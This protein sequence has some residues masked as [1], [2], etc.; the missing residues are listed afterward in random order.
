VAESKA[1]LSAVLRHSDRPLQLLAVR[2]PDGPFPENSWQ[3]SGLGYAGCES[4]ACENVPIHGCPIAQPAV[5]MSDLASQSIREWVPIGKQ[6]FAGAD[7]CQF[8]KRGQMMFNHISIGVRSLPKSKKF[9]DAALGAIGYTCLSEDEGSLGY[10]KRRVRLWILKVEKPVPR[11][12]K[13]GLHLCFDARTR[14][15]VVKFHAAGLAQAGKDNGKPG[16]R[17][18]YAPDYFA[19]YLVDPDGYRIEAYCRVR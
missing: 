8:S 7:D 9:Y 17:K 10:G 15:S 12:P 5:T 16:L 11:N 19:A 18:D 14:A 6:V 13:S 1:R 2:K 4:L 3:L